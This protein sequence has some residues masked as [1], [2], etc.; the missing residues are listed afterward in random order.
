MYAISRLHTKYVFCTHK[1]HRAHKPY[2]YAKNPYNL[3]KAAYRTQKPYNLRTQ[4]DTSILKKS[5]RNKNKN[6][7]R[8]MA[9]GEQVKFTRVNR[10]WTKA[11]KVT[12]P[13]SLED[14]LEKE[15]QSSIEDRNIRVLSVLADPANE[16]STCIKRNIRIFG[17]HKNLIDVL[18]ARLVIEQ[19]ITKNNITMG[20]NQYHF[21]K[22]FLDGEALRI[23]DLKSTELSHETVANLIMVMNDVVTYFS[24]NSVSPSRNATS[25]TRWRNHAS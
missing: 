6:S 13:I 3:R 16:D 23:F 9:H 15:V 7:L 10:Y 5:A 4:T 14:L 24:Q 25:V 22:T 21:T 19:G 1:S 17:D 2:K 18:C 11:R 20:P 8:V 12:A